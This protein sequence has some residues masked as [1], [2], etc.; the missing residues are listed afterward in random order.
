MKIVSENQFSG[1]PYF[2][3]IGPCGLLPLRVAERGHGLAPLGVERV[4]VG[5]GEL[6]LG[7]VAH[8]LRRVVV[9][10]CKTGVMTYDYRVGLVVWQ[11]GWVDL[12]LE[13]STILL[14]Q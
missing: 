5:L 8:V 7:R 10:L 11:L 1:K 9:R 2:Y 4:G 3:T 14:G 12:D 13:C 6:R